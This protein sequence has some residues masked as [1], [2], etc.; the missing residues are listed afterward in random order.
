MP[1]LKDLATIRAIN[2]ES[3][4]VR[5]VGQSG[6]IMKLDF[7]LFSGGT[8][9]LRELDLET[10]RLPLTSPIFCGL[11]RLRL[12]HARF[13]GN[14]ENLAHQLLRVISVCPDLEEL[15]LRAI[16]P[17]INA[18]EGSHLFRTL[19]LSLPCLRKFTLDQIKHPRVTRALLESIQFPPAVRVELAS[20]IYDSYIPYIPNASLLDSLRVEWGYRRM[21]GWDRDGNELLVLNGSVDDLH[22]YQTPN[23]TR[24]SIELHRHAR[25]CI[26]F[27]TTAIQ[28]LPL[29]T[30]IWVTFCGHEAPHD[31]MSDLPN[32]LARPTLRRVYLVDCHIRPAVLESVR[33]GLVDSQGPEGS[34]VALT[35]VDCVRIH[36]SATSVWL[37]PPPRS[38]FTLR[39]AL[40]CQPDRENLPQDHYF[41]EHKDE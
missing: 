38:A 16:Y 26:E 12:A 27:L 31:I 28:H 24:L 11:T 20:S 35:L 22:H 2:L 41:P 7:D 8:P 10:I 9:C 21:K 30:H 4:R 18:G 3:L 36:D 25:S 1:M 37:D 6:A 39:G 13:A 32:A 33:S 19:H 40:R 15:Y 34:L 23:V 17:K 5:L 29:L 14:D